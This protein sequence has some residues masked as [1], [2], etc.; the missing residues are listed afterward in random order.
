MSA[1]D[2][3]SDAQPARPARSGAKKFLAYPRKA[4]AAPDT[5]RE[6]RAAASY[7]VAVS[8]RSGGQTGARAVPFH[9]RAP[10]LSWL[11]RRTVPTLP[12]SRRCERCRQCR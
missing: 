5:Q 4:C 12:R 7:N 9:P 2:T 10:C 3:S 8:A 11:A 1:F 6:G